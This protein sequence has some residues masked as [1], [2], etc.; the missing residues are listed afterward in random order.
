MELTRGIAP[1]DAGLA[2]LLGVVYYH[3]NQLEKAQ[4]EF[5]RAIGIDANHSNA[6][7]FLGLIYDRLGNKSAALEQF[8]KIAE[9]NPDNAEV[10]KIIENLQ[11]NRAALDGIVPP[12]Q[13]PAERL[14]A[15]VRD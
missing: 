4:S 10:K 7:Y 2:F 9:L 6:R 13:P 1:F 8:K 12:D 11:N 5:E 15:P 3:D 14:E